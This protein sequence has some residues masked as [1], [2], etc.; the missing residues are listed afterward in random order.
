[1]IGQR[2]VL[3]TTEVVVSWVAYYGGIKLVDRFLPKLLTPEQG[4]ELKKQFLS[5]VKIVGTTIAIAIFA[6]MLAAIAREAVESKFWPEIENLS[7]E[8]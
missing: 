2:I 3:A 1:M 7:I 8:E 6:S 5:A 4:L